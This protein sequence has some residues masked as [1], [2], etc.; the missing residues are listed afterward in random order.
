MELG[1]QSLADLG[2]LVVRLAVGLTFAA[3]GAQKVLGWWGGPGF[4]GCM[5]A[6]GRM[7]YSP[8]TFW[9]IV[10]AYV[11]ELHKTICLGSRLRGPRLLLELNHRAGSGFADPSSLHVAV[12]RGLMPSRVP[13]R[14]SRKGV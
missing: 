9:A 5:G 6:V 1:P 13:T 4:A 3:H 8:A 14:S 2:V 10:S 12:R 7:R 11:L